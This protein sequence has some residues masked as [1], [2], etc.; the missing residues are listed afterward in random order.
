MTEQEQNQLN[1]YLFGLAKKENYKK[2]T[3]IIKEG[4]VS[5][6]FYYLEKGILR[7]WT[8]NDG[9][10]ITFQFLFEEQL[11]CATESFFYNTP[12]SYSIETIE[13]SVLLYIDKEEMNLLQNDKSFEKLFNKYL[14][15]R[16]ALYQN[17]LIARIQDKPE[18][19]YRKLFQEKPE[20][21]LRIPQ[22]YVASYLGITPVSLSRIRNRQ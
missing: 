18:V 10:E 11:F 12:C 19:R 7:G 5:S 3:I 8:N 14:I 1:Q 20:I 16:L 9:K 4:E 2:G 22:H 15:S 13:D 17:L 6:K 21:L